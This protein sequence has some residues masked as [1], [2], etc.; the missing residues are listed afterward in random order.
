MLALWELA[1][2]EPAVRISPGSDCPA[3]PFARALEERVLR[4]E[5]A[6]AE[7][8]GL[9]RFPGLVSNR[10][11][12]RILVLR[13]SLEFKN[14]ASMN[15]AKLS[16]NGQITVP[17]EVRRRLHLVPGDKVLFLEKPSGE[18]VVAKAGLTALA[19]AQA[20]F[21]GAAADIGVSDQ[22]GVQSLVDDARGRVS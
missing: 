2:P 1:A 16:A 7:R 22:D 18:V 20:T 15:L 19:Q 8:R 13:N 12:S 17:V 6:D 10:S 3:S 14:R 4:L 9:F 11:A 21:A 5:Y